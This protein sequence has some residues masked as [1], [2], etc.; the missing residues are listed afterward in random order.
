MLASNQTAIFKVGKVLA[1]RT[2]RDRLFEMFFYRTNA[3]KTVIVVIIDGLVRTTIARIVFPV[4]CRGRF[5]RKCRKK[6]VPQQKPSPRG[7]GD[8][9]HAN[10]VCL[11]RKGRTFVS[12]QHG[13]GA[14]E[15]IDCV[16]EGSRED[17]NNITVGAGLSVVGGEFFFL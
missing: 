11:R 14:V 9:R 16:C 6:Q 12:V 1:K 17:D 13:R 4:T 7:H 10:S 3:D 15:K 2:C 5:V 8:A